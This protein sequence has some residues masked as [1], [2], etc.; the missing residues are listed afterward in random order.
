[1]KCASLIM[2]KNIAHLT[3]SFFA[4]WTINLIMR[5][6]KSARPAA[7]PILAINSARA[8]NLSCNGV[9][10][11]SVRSAENKEKKTS[12]RVIQPK[13]RRTHHNPTVETLR[14]NSNDDIA[15]NALQNFNSTDNETV[16][17]AQ[18]HEPVCVL[19][20]HSCH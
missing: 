17:V 15:P 19:R 3:G 11:E 6:T 5:A 12:R 1:M 4:S 7:L 14:A 8:F 18:S 16:C 10:S 2:A 9:F 20:R 13:K